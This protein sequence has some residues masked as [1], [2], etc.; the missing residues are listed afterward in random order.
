MSDLKIGIFLRQGCGYPL[1]NTGLGP[2]FVAVV[3]RLGRAVFK[4][5][6]APT[7]AA[8]QA[9]MM[10]DSTLRSSTRG[11]PRGLFGSNGLI[12]LNCSLR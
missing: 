8:L 10:P 1:E 6:V 2:A 4:W 11:T 7:I 9:K 12:L 3:K 5:H